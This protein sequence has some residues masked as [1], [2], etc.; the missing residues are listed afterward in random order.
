MYIYAEHT[1]RILGWRKINKH[2]SIF[3]ISLLNVE[4]QKL[5][6]STHYYAKYRLCKLLFEH[7]VS[8]LYL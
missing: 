2:V 3:Y 6:L 4:Y 5:L 8:I 7:S 1:Q